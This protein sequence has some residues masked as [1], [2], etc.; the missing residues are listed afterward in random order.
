[1][2]HALH[3]HCPAGLAEVIQLF[4]FE[5]RLLQIEFAAS[6]RYQPC[7]HVFCAGKGEQFL[8]INQ[9]FEFGEGSPDQQGF[10]LPVIAQEFVNGQ[11]AEQWKFAFHCPDYSRVTPGQG[12]Q[13][14]FLYDLRKVFKMAHGRKHQCLCNLLQE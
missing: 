5:W 2:I 7:L 11:S 6:L 3:Q 14:I 10:L 13:Q 9:T 12:T 4:R 1:M 8:C